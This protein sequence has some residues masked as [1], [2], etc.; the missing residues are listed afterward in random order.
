MR[1]IFPKLHIFLR[2][3]FTSQGVDEANNNGTV[4]RKVIVRVKNSVKLLL[5]I[6]P[7][8]S[9]SGRNKERWNGREILSQISFAL[10]GLAARV[11]HLFYR[12]RAV[13][14]VPY[15]IRPWYESCV[16][17]VSP[18]YLVI[19]CRHVRFTCAL[20]VFALC[21]ELF[22]HRFVIIRLLSSKIQIRDSY[23]LY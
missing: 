23:E 9:G 20:V 8:F 17:L 14:R 12:F 5:Y 11:N 22:Q 21:S 18:S 13:F 10:T 3:S 4:P 19:H 15:V 1:V 2:I 6:L 16:R 7:C